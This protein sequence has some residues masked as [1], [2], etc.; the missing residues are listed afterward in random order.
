[1]KPFRLNR[2]SFIGTAGT[3]IGLPLLE[4]MLPGTRSA[5]AASAR[6]TRLLAYYVPCGIHMQAW[7]PAQ[8]GRSYTLSP[9]LAP[10][11]NVKDD[12]L[13]LSNLSNAITD[14]PG[15]GAHATGTGGFLTCT[16]VLKSTTDILN[17]VSMDQIAA[18]QLQGQTRFS[19]LELG[20]AGGGNSGDCDSGYSCAYARN[21]AWSAPKTP[22]PKITEPL[23]LFNRLFAGSNSQ[24]STTEAAIRAQRTQSVLDYALADTQKLQQKLGAADRAK[25]DE[26]LT[27][28]QKLE[29][30]LKQNSDDSCKAPSAPL[31][32]AN[33][34]QKAQT[35]ADLMAIA[36]ECDLTRVQTFMLENAGT[37]RIYDFLG[38][39]D[40]HHTV[41][42]H[43]SLQSNYDKLKIIDHWEV[44]QYTYLLEKLKATKDIEGIP[45]LDSCMVYFSSEISDGD[46]HNKTNMPVLL[47]GKANGYLDTGQ[48]IKYSNN[49]K[50]ASLFVSLLEAMGVAPAPF[51]D[52][53][54]VLAG[55]KKTS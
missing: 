37:P 17:G 26:Y 6:P 16:L 4:A 24:Q 49:E 21:I 29:A 45:L 18:K 38:L 15:N 3:A 39:A 36:F 41:S 27:G 44:Q 55:I 9:T 32:G 8:T 11:A 33:W 22:L 25:L 10:L 40:D 50:V 2:R 20:M 52:A 53:T 13:V 42:H 43:Q 30:T 23:D 1:M 47:A 34:T 19:S 54:G 48:H 35:M 7:T 14:P 51:G 28:I 5:F 12:L 46:R 31:A